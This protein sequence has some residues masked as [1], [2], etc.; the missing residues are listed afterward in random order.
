MQD[1]FESLVIRV[2]K[3]VNEVDRI[4]HVEHM[5]QSDQA[6]EGSH[7][8]LEGISAEITQ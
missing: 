1:S 8:S 2:E 6:L 3:A 5:Q 4:I 7:H